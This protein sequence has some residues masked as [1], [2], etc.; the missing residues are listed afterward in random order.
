LLRQNMG[1]ELHDN[2][3]ESILDISPIFEIQT[4][5][6]TTQNILQQSH[7][8]KKVDRQ[9]NGEQKLSSQQINRI[10]LKLLEGHDSGETETN[11]IRK[12]EISLKK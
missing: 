7:S 5:E 4:F 10:I 9:Y 6:M 8:S 11:I 1:E 3:L 12:H 2:F